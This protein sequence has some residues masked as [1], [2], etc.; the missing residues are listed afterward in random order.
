M[1]VKILII[2]RSFNNMA[3]GIERMAAALMNEMCKRGHD[4]S[5]L[6]W[7]LAGAKSFYDFDPR[8]KWYS[9]NMGTHTKKASWLLRFKRMLKMRRMLR[10][11]NPQ[12]IM[13]FQHG[14]FF[15]TRLYSIGQGFPI[16][17]AE[18]E[19]PARFEHI[20]AG[21][22]R[23]FIYQ[24]F[25]LAKKIT[26]QCE[27]F[28]EDYPKYLHNK[29]ITIANPV[30]PAKCHAKPYGK[31]SKRK[32]LLSVGR[33]SY[34]KNQIVLIKAFAKIC[35]QFPDW[36]LLIAGEGEDRET[37]ESEVKKLHL[38]D[39]ISLPG[40]SKNVE[41]L[42]CQSHLSCLPAR[43]EGFPNVV[44]ESLAHGLPVIGF[45]GC[46]GTRDLI[47]HGENGLLAKGNGDV[48][49]LAETLKIAMS[50]DCLR[51]KMGKAGIE[52]VKQ[53]EPETIFDMWENLFKEVCRK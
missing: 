39:R 6:T 35:D 14:T 32:I 31:G 16:I 24:S 37:L 33:L 17:A 9:L 5:L 13:A 20:K 51:E 38:E 47:K 36:D 43:W 52:S 19:A 21:K 44:A 46:A 4:V 41:Q 2:C 28:T 3:G 26:I 10:E 48:E 27:S 23:W 7:D 22:R 25:R 49:T 45:A 18:R 11:I 42:Y 34:Q 12:I 50:D 30:F 29:I 1:T 53:Y 8:I 40:A 15:S